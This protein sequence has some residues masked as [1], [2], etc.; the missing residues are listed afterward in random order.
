MKPQ[1]TKQGGGFR[2]FKRTVKDI[3]K[4]VDVADELAAL[5]LNLWACVVRDIQIEKNFVLDEEGSAR[6]KTSDAR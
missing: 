5:I 3:L 1:R 4:K 2:V 6:L